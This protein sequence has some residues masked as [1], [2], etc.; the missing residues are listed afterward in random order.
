M[1]CIYVPLF[2][3]I[4]YVYSFIAVWF[5]KIFSGSDEEYLVMHHSDIF[6]SDDTFL[7]PVCLSRKSNNLIQQCMQNSL[8]SL[9]YLGF[10]FP[11]FKSCRFMYSVF[12]RRA[13][14]WGPTAQ[15]WCGPNCHFKAM[16]I[17][18]FLRDGS[19]NWKY[20]YIFF[21]FSHMFLIF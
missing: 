16:R 4:S 20:V 7:L 10:S 21:Y 8:K 1:W 18:H 13:K 17:Y 15:P 9:K 6:H 12:I 2:F 11:S 14:W 5:F 19:F 3:L